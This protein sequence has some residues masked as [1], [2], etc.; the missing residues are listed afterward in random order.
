MFNSLKCLPPQSGNSFSPKPELREKTE[1]FRFV[2]VFDTSEVKFLTLGLSICSTITLPLDNDLFDS[3]KSLS[4]ILTITSCSISLAANDT[5]ESSS[6]STAHITASSF[7]SIVMG[8]G[9]HS[10]RSSL[11]NSGTVIASK[12]Y[13]IVKLKAVVSYMIDEPFF[14]VACLSLLRTSLSISASNSR[15]A[16]TKGASG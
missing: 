9:S 10:S 7:T 16:E 11:R 13:I 14:K 15:I 4:T 8:E 6:P 5:D 1:I 12:P 3:K 2:A